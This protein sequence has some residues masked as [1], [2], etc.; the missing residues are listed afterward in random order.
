M[1][2]YV[3]LRGERPRGEPVSESK[4]RGL[5]KVSSRKGLDYDGP[6]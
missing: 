4:S 6:L 3:F 1:S 5:E 2:R